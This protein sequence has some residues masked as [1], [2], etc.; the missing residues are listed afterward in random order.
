[1]RSRVSRTNPIEIRKEQKISNN[2]KA[3]SR[4]LIYQLYLEKCP[5]NV[6]SETEKIK[7]RQLSGNENQV[8]SPLN[9]QWW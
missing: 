9:L 6:A 4:D 2:F 7:K 5:A 3:M 8:S 1:M